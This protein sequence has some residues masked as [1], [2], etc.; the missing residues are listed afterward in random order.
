MAAAAADMAE[1][2]MAAAAGGMEAGMV[3][4]AGAMVEEAGL[5]AAGAAG[6]MAAAT[7]PTMANRTA[8]VAAIAAAI[9]GRRAGAAG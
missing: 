3:M 1:A 7:I 9:D 4:A 6:D 8:V 2:D 5:M